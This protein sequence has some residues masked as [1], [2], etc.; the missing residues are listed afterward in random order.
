MLK[1]GENTVAEQS[2]FKRCVP[3]T[4]FN[5]YWVNSHD[6]VG[7]NTCLA[8]RISTWMCVVCDM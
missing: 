4:L 8:A 1:S 2:R 7:M 3:F 5:L 6:V